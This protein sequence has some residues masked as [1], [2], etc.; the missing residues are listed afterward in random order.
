MID[1][2]IVNKKILLNIYHKN[3]RNRLRYGKKFMNGSREF[4][5]YGHYTWRG[6]YEIQTDRHHNYGNR[7]DYLFKLK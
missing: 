5:S 6:K 1:L 7:D 3:V 2:Y 4:G